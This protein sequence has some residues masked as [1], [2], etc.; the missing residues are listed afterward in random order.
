M[1]AEVLAEHGGSRGPAD[2]GCLESTLA[3]PRN[4][5]AYGEPELPAL[6]ASYGYGLGRN[7][8]FT[9]GNKR[10]ALTAMDVFLQLNGHEL[11]ATEPEAV[12]TLELL[13]GG[14]LEEADL[15]AWIQHHSQ[16]LP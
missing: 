2:E 8:C 9:D 3:R 11:T 16:P 5:A 10:I 1:H 6:A 12:V 15:A 13:A 14:E 4:L 7:H